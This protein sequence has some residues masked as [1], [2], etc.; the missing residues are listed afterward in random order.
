[1][2]IIVIFTLDDHGITQ[3]Y[4]HSNTNYKHKGKYRNL[5]TD[6]NIPALSGI[7]MLKTFQIVDRFGI[8]LVCC[9]PMFPVLN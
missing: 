8:H 9:F 3:L 1:M 6:L 5:E 7:P 2:V 4:L